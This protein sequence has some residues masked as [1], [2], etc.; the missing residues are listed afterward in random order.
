MIAS[1]ARDCRGNV[2]ILFGIAA[3][4]LF[5]G[6]AIAVDYSD[7]TRL[8]ASLSAA[9][10]AAALAGARQL[11]GASKASEA[12]AK[13]EAARFVTG[14]HPEASQAIQAS[15]TQGTV[16]VDLS[17]QRDMLFGGILS[18]D[19]MPVAAHAVAVNGLGPSPCMVA[20]GENE[21]IG[22]SLIGSAKISASKCTVASNSTGPNSIYL[23]GAAKLIG[24]EVC[25]AGGTS[26]ANTSPPPETCGTIADPYTEKPLRSDTPSSEESASSGASTYAGPCDFT[27]KVVDAHKGTTE[28]TPGIYCGG[29][30]I[31]SADVVLKPGLYVMQDGPLSMQGNASLSGTGVSILL[32]GLNAILDMQGSPT[33]TLEAM[34]T[35]SLAGIAIASDTSASPVLTSVLQGSPDLTVTGSI[36]LPNQRLEM[37]GSPVL[38][39]LGPS[40]SL[41]AL[42]F[43]LQGSPDIKIASDSNTMANVPTGVWLV[44]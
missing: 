4:V 41:I 40:D 38:N 37:R 19:S 18:I 28:L 33:M 8:R 6:V 11:D 32:S 24:S 13:A 43:K 27:N 9:A 42:S 16:T 29:L 39:T 20:L 35:G 5:A 10:D 36:Y 34:D 17:V 44:E 2:A 23:Q 31:Q 12:A 26:K 1:F 30:S 25:V 22:I 21:P 15:V 14:K 3:P 7:A